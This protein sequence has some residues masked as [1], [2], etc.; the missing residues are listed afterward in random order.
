MEGYLLDMLGLSKIIPRKKRKQAVKQVTYNGE[1]LV[2]IKL[3]FKILK[4]G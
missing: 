2:E 3:L 4:N 1:G